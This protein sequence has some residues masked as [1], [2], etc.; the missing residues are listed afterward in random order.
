[1][2]KVRLTT[3]FGTKVAAKA[4]KEITNAARG[5]ETFEEKGVSVASIFHS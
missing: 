5:L 3:E 2:L 4:L 1:M